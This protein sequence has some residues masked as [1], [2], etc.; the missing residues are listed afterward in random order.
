M[1]VWNHDISKEKDSVRKAIGIVFQDPSLDDELTGRENLDF[2]GRLYGMGKEYREER[3]A[4]V[5]KL[6]EET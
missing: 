3:I 6:I 4:E 2:H 5:L 1:P